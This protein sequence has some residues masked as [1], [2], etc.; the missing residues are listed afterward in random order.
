MADQ[1]CQS[2]F[3]LRNVVSLPTDMQT[4]VKALQLTPAHSSWLSMQQ[5]ASFPDSSPKHVFT[6]YKNNN[7]NNN[8]NK[9]TL[10]SGAW[11]RG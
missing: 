2:V 3:T 9:A 10:G 1:A 11:E 7:N 6:L 4:S 8:N 5:P